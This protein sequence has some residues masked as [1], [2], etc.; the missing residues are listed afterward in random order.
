MFPSLQNATRSV[1]LI[2]EQAPTWTE[3]SREETSALG[4]ILLATVESIMLA[5]LLTPS[6]NVSQTVQTE[7]LGNAYP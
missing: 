2:L 3:L 1:S 4:T 5:S 7:Y 6:G